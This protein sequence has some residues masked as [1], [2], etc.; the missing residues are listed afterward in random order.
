MCLCWLRLCTSFGVWTCLRM[1][2][3]LC[4]FVYLYVCVQ[5][6][7]C[8]SMCVCHLV[9]FPMLQHVQCIVETL[10]WR[11]KSWAAVVSRCQRPCKVAV[12]KTCH[13]VCFDCLHW[14]KQCRHSAA[15]CVLWQHAGVIPKSVTYTKL[16]PGVAVLMAWKPLEQ[17]PAFWNQWCQCGC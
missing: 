16:G 8:A 3:F 9:L 7:V 10:I 1:W 5:A 6:C 14:T 15:L 17:Q 13:Y 2:N 11:P 12:K 4:A